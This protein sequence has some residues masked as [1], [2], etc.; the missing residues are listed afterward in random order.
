MAPPPHPDHRRP[1]RS[2]MNESSSRRSRD[3]NHNRREAEEAGMSSSQT[4]RRSNKGEHQ[5]PEG[6]TV[7][8][9]RHHQQNEQDK[10][11]SR[12]GKSRRHPQS[13]VQQK[14]LTQAQGD[15]IDDGSSIHSESLPNNS[16]TN[17]QQHSQPVVDAI[18]SDHPSSSVIQHMRKCTLCHRTLPR[19]QF[20]DRDRYT[21]HE[22][23]A[24]G[25]ICRTCAMTISAVRLRGVPTTEN[26]LM[27]YAERGEQMA[28]MIADRVLGAY[29]DKESALV[30]SNQP[31][32]NNGED[33]M[34]IRQ[35]RSESFE[36]VYKGS[37]N[38]SVHPTTS[39]NRTLNS[40]MGMPTQRIPDVNVVFSG[41]QYGGGEE[42]RPANVADCKYIDALLRLPSYLNLNAYGI[43]QSSE[44]VSISM[45]TLEAVRLYGTLEQTY[46]VP[47]DTEG[48]PAKTR[49]P[50]PRSMLP[51]E[52]PKIVEEEGVD[53][54]SIVCLVLGEGRT[55]R[56][57]V[58]CAVHYGWTSYA[59]DPTLSEGW[60]GYHEDIPGF[61][62]YSGTVAEFVD[63]TEDSIIEIQNQSVKHLVIIGIQKEKDKLRLKGNA[64]VCEIRDRYNDVPTTLVSISPVRKATLAP[65]RRKG[66]YMSKLEK[67]IGY[68][69]NISFLDGAVFSECRLI[70]VWNFH[71]ADDEEGLGSDFDS[72]HDENGSQDVM[73]EHRFHRGGHGNWPAQDL[74][75]EMNDTLN[76]PQRTREE[77]DPGKSPNIHDCD[78]DDNEE[79]DDEIWGKALAKH[80][81][82][83]QERFVNQF[84][85]LYLDNVSPIKEELE[86]TNSELE[87]DDRVDKRTSHQKHSHAEEEANDDL[88]HWSDENLNWSDDVITDL[89]K[90]KARSPRKSQP[91]H[92]KDDDTNSFDGFD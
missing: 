85:T 13:H 73:E 80:D 70:E 49:K 91:W 15:S 58:L 5:L 8:Q 45:A 11:S 3:N 69:P 4:L 63:N 66:Q 21:I 72:Y 86:R 60:D 54:K 47:H 22:S 68:D 59:I 89:P 18:P 41:Q 53:P 27:A 77:M 39:S 30:T 48:L 84:E 20:S 88:I 38:D 87:T 51:M 35:D 50:N 62:G 56:T 52:E 79:I 67:D 33:A 23:L 29:S 19:A 7:A 10:A 12:R 44:D 2:K 32:D 9:F 76:E 36:M 25:A 40:T 46:F 75:Q 92:K 55:P 83:E 26:M 37:P 28:S 78:Y 31:T 65:K 57:A 90:G 16:Y 17:Q 14:R 42:D 1:S 81:E 6:V 24:S 71:N 43:F 34:V 74:G 61:T 64:H 82:E